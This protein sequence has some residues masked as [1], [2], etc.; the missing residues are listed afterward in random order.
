MSSVNVAP[1]SLEGAV[2]V[3]DALVFP[4]VAVPIV[5]APG[6]VA[7]FTGVTLLEAADAAPVPASVAAVTV[8]V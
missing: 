4:R 5:G 3:T 2:N 6:T 8:N 7:E 1:P